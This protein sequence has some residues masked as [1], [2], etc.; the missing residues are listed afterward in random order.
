M[1]L[2]SELQSIR[3]KM[4]DY[5]A[6]QHSLGDVPIREVRQQLE[7]CIKGVQEFE[8]KQQ[9]QQQ[10]VATAKATLEIMDAKLTHSEIVL[11]EL[12]KE[13]SAREGHL[14]AQLRSQKRQIEDLQEREAYLSREC[15]CHHS[16]LQ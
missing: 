15:H 8:L 9:S 14:L 12:R 7:R 1:L 10:T 11:G 13:F 3:G 16:E 2:K 6:L 4:V 5:D